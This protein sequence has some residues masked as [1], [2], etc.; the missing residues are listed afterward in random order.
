ML[1]TIC[2]RARGLMPKARGELGLRR[3]VP[4]PS[5][6]ALPIE[7]ESEGLGSLPEIVQIF[8]TKWYILCTL[9][10][11][12]VDFRARNMYIKL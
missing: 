12:L 5:Q 9:E 3:S 10:Y 11:S 7:K 4:L 8:V 2:G 1:Y 6:Q